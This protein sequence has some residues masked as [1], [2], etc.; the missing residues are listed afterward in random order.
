LY[1][2][3]E[4]FGYLIEA[5]GFAIFRSGDGLFPDKSH[6][7]LYSMGKKEFDLVFVDRIFLERE[8]QELINSFINTKKTCLHAF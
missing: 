5:D 4:N 8:G 7:E 2:G 6:F 1:S 3:V